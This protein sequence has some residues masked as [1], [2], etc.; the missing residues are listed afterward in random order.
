MR[1]I[2]LIVIYFIISIILAY[3]AELSASPTLSLKGISAVAVKIDPLPDFA[4]SDGA[5]EIALKQSAEQQLTD[6]GIKIVQY[7]DWEKMLGGSYL[8]IKIV[9]SRSYS[10]EKYVIYTEI[11]LYQA[12]VLIKAQLEQNRIIH[13]NTW[14]AGKL[15]NCDSISVNT[16]L[17]KSLN[18][19]VD[20]FISDYKKVN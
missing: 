13:G 14:S 11:E 6:E 15:M 1:V 12:V 19:L 17:L 10:A 5:S 8:Y 7:K 4:K 20:I 18:Q 2:K 3:Q 9:P 16:C